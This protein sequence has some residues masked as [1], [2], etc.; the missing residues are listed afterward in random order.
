PSRSL[1]VGG[2]DPTLTSADIIPIFRQFGVIESVRLLPDKEC[3]FV[4]FAL[5]EDA[6]KAR[7]ELA[8]NS[9]KI[10][11][12]LIRVAFGKG[13]AHMGNDAQA[14][15]PTKSIWIGNLAPNTTSQML[16]DVFGEYGI[17]ESIRVL[18]LKNCGFVN[19]EKL[20]D[21]VRAKNSIVGKEINGAV[22]RVGY[23]KVLAPQ[24]TT[25]TAESD[26][27]TT[28]VIMPT[29]AP[30]AAALAAA[31]AA[32]AGGQEGV[33]PDDILEPG[34]GLIID[35]RLI[36]YRYEREVPQ[37]PPPHPSIKMDQT[38]LRDI[39]RKMD[40]D[41]SGSDF[42]DSIYNEYIEAVVDLSVDYIGNIVVQKLFER[43]ST[44]QRHEI[45]KRISPYLVTIGMHKNGT[46]A[47]QKIIDCAKTDLEMNLIIQSIRP[48]TPLL[49]NNQLG[50]YVVQ[51]CLRFGQ[52]YNQ[53]VF[54]TIHARCLD[55]AQ[56]RFGARAV[57]TCLESQHATRVQQK[58]VA[59]S[60]VVNAVALAAS[61]NGSLLMNWLL[62]SSAFVGR[63]RV[64]A[65]QLVPQLALLCNSKLGQ[66]TVLK[67]IH[68]RQ[69]PDARDLLLGALFFSS[70]P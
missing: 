38:R 17:I 66:T 6:I 36:V 45:I 29:V 43:G 26:S 28:M 25:A 27:K 39:R 9:R 49:L 33:N 70:A 20:E 52:P 44:K 62:D 53:F 10:G 60:L 7:A 15:Q 24:Q 50:N 4:N 65:P 19:F 67:L 23:A 13:E 34:A 68:Q 63:F 3:A 61:P 8:S 21:A 12:S 1:W 32:V 37:L 40:I 64:L 59:V 14:M 69:E 55:I 51:C 35:E 2:L 47:V 42:V 18:T 56:N 46:W 58:Q 22:V 31:A 48:H 54:D 30:V 16:Q 57:R 5:L 41:S 11:N